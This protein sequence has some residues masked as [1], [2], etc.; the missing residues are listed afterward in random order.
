VKGRSSGEGCPYCSG[1]RVL[2]GYNDLE[3][4]HPELVPEWSEKNTDLSPNQ[5]TAGSHK[6]VWW[7]GKCGHE[8]QA[9]IKN[10]VQGAGCPY[11]SSNKILV[12][13]NDLATT[14]PELAAE[15]SD[16]NLLLTPHDVMA[17]SNRK[18]WWR[19]R[20]HGHEWETL[21]PT[22]SDGSGCPYCS[23]LRI[24]EG[25]NDLAAT[26]PELAAEWSDKNLPL[27]PEDINEKSRRNVWWKCRR[28]GH[29]WQRVV[30]TRVQGSGCPCCSGLVVKAGY[31]DLA[32][33]DPEL[34][35]EWDFAQNTELTP[36]TVH[37]FSYKSVWWHGDCGHH[38]K[39][40]I[41]NRAVDHEGCLY[42]DREFRTMF[43]SL[44]IMYA[45]RKNNIQVVPDERKKTGMSLQ[46]FLPKQDAAIELDSPQE[47]TKQRCD[48]ER[49][50]EMICR[51]QGIRLIRILDPGTL[52][53]NV[54]YWIRQEDDSD[55]AFEEALRKAF[56]TAG[57]FI[58]T[59]IETERE[60]LFN[61]FRAWKKRQG[62]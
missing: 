3:T 9:V 5:V 36:E 1:K 15:W 47:W 57:V 12:G 25:F 10:R 20:E 60:V 27:R 35:K 48:R 38:W 18:A 4:L 26:H 19:C 56:N 21:I 11:C 14:N 58:R 13:F 39:A 54:P 32:T 33:T 53:V 29:E 59:E 43:P 24:L 52:E 2:A 23:G 42:C 8:W 16:R 41:V 22:R 31:N 40:K 44:Y 55:A 17:Y 61:M 45:A 49:I 46:F 6:K 34:I 62:K 30:T 51:K 28:C 37:R 50:K 7:R